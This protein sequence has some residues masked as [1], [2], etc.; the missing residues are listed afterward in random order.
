MRTLRNTE[1]WVRI[2]DGVNI[3]AHIN[4]TITGIVSETLVCV[5]QQLC[6]L[7]VNEQNL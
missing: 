2:W 5:S 3:D 4:K 1:I 7:H 6:V